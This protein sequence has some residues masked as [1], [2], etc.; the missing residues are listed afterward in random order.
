MTARPSLFRSVVRSYLASVIGVA[1]AIAVVGSLVASDVVVQRDDAAA[2]ALARTL[3]SELQ[4]HAGE[5]LTQLDELVDHELEEQRWFVRRVEV[6]RAG[7]RIGGQ[8]QRSLPAAW[9]VGSGCHNARG[10]EAW[11]RVCVVALAADTKVVVASDLAP[12]LA[13]M[14]PFVFAI[15][16]AALATALVFALLSRHVVRRSLEP[17]R[18]FEASIATLPALGRERR[19]A[20]RWGAEEIDALAQTF[21]ALLERI[22]LAVE[23]EQ[24]F[25]ADAAHELRTPLTRLRG[26]I[27]LVLGLGV[28]GEAKDRLTRAAGTCEELGRTTEALLALARDEAS[29]D[30]AVDL[31]EVAQLCMQRLEPSR[32]GRVTLTTSESALVRGDEALLLLAA[33]NLLDNALKYTCD[34]VLLQVVVHDGSCSVRIEDRGEGIDKDEL[35]RIR[36]PFV[37]GQVRPTAARGTGLGLALVDHV[38]RLHGGS[39]LLAPRTPRGLC[40]EVR[41]PAWQSERR[42]G[43][44]PR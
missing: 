31:S 10:A 22:D 32:S 26:Q 11:Q 2:R 17:L 18:H 20:S 25:V 16:G 24:R 40:A 41:L 39:L 12:L 7:R 44:A 28:E 5:S 3:G 38:A 36:E 6:W 9:R 1:A 27:E 30:D 21:N 23:R 42:S 33:T 19:M 14:L 4:N 15:G 37:R 29:R 35:V 34:E 13:S 8:A 43:R